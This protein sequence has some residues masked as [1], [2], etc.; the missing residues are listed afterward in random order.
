MSSKCTDIEKNRLNKRED[1]TST[2]DDIRCPGEVT[3]FDA[4]TPGS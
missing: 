1:K 2:P 3:K 4:P